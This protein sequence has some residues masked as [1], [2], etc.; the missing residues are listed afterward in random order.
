MGR[1]RP[2][3]LDRGPIGEAID[4]AMKI[5]VAF[6][7]YLDDGRL[8]IDNNAVE[9][10]LRCVAIG[11]KNWMFVGDEEGG[12]R[13]AIL[14][15]LVNTCREIGIDP[16]QYFR[17]VLLR[18]ATCSDVTKLTRHGWSQHQTQVYADRRRANA[19]CST[20]GDPR[21]GSGAGPDRPD[22]DHRTHTL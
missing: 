1:V 7:R 13:A 22:G 21:S 11:R 3:V 6:S 18:I 4:Y 16:K 19:S 15:S 2:T 14:F 5:R 8:S 20:R 12:R 10:A 9:R 17:D